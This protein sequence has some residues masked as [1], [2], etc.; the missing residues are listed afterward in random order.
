VR[1][2]VPIE[3]AEDAREL[4]QVSDEDEAPTDETSTAES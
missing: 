3:R 2:L 4:L 1:I